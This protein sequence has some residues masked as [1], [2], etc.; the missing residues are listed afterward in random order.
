MNDTKDKAKEELVQALNKFAD[1]IYN[2]NIVFATPALVVVQVADAIEA[3]INA[4]YSASYTAGFNDAIDAVYKSSPAKNHDKDL[5]DECV[6]HTKF[7][8]NLNKEGK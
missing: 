5:M 8:V 1:Y 7:L 2:V 3:Y 4:D 6:A